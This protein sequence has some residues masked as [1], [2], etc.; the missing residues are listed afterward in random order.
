MAVIPL[1]D[2]SDTC[3]TCTC[4]CVRHVGSERTKMRTLVTSV[5]QKLEEE[6]TINKKMKRK[7]EEEMEVIT[8]NWRSYKRA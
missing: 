1:E 2:M 7:G 3:C 4:D 6:E 8:K 5:M